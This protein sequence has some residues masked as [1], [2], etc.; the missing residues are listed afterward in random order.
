MREGFYDY[1]G[2]KESGLI[3][4]VNA[5]GT[6]SGT[7]NGTQIKKEEYEATIVKLIKENN[8]ITRKQIA[9]ELSVSLRTVQRLLN[10]IKGL[11]HIGSGRGGYWEYN[12]K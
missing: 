11:K 4:S 7:H 10:S 9:S 2:V 1:E 6:H 3:E 12:E 8:R 5:N